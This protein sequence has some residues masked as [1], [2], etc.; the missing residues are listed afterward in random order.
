ML[1]V[2]KNACDLEK[3]SL[4]KGRVHIKNKK[5]YGNS[6]EFVY[7]E[8]LLTEGITASGY[9]SDLKEMNEFHPCR[10]YGLK[11]HLCLSF[12]GYAR[13]EAEILNAVLTGDR[14]GLVYSLQDNFSSLGITH[15]IAI[16]GLNMGIVFLLGYSFVFMIMRL[17]IPL[18]LRLDTPFAA[19][20]AGL[21]CV[22]L[23]TLFVGYSAPAVRSAIMVVCFVTSFILIRKPS[24]I[25]S[26]ALSGIII[27]LWMPG[28]LFSA[29][30]LLSFAA[31]LGL[32]GMYSLMESYPKWVVYAAVPIVSMAFTAPIVI[33]FFG[34]MSPIS[35]LANLVFVP[36]FS[37][38]I[39]PLG[40]AGI[41]AMA[42]SEYLSGHLLS[43][44]FDCISII[45]KTS[46]LVGSLEPIRCPGKAWIAV[47][48]CGLVTAFFSRPS[49][50]KNFILFPCAILVFAIPVFLQ[51]SRIYDPLC[52]DFISVGQGDSILVS[53]GSKA[54]LID[55]G[56][57]P[58]GSDTG[59]FIVG[60]HLLRRWIT[61]LDLVVITHSHPD[62]IGGMAFILKR[63][64]VKEI[65]SNVKTDWNTDFQSVIGIAQKKSIPLKNVCLDDTCHM[66]GL[67][68]EVLNPPKRIMERTE[69]LDLNLHSVVLRIGDESMKGLF[70]ADAGGLGEIRLSRL[71]RDISADVLKAAHHGSK[72]SCFSMFLDRVHPHFV[73]I[74]VGKD[75]I[76]RLPHRSVLDRLKERAIAVHRTDC[77][78]EVK[79]YKENNILQVKSAKAY[80]DNRLESASACTK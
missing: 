75:N 54:I 73:V 46:D 63:F 64:P 9:I 33:Y 80:T 24:L 66:R 43:I 60:P 72:N 31:V 4:L 6:G 45:L 69:D 35:I 27:L 67:K 28:S 58:Y 23:Y 78:G 14:S 39:M 34:F 7:Q 19:K 16:S 10:S 41:A 11:K 2:Y 53:K 1:S 79:F 51:I 42:V 30:F 74:T 36:W 55:A 71:E 65:W 25:E 38:I 15:L 8:Y 57:S 32:I 20:S 61:S 18:S 13:P 17:V 48:Y 37:F 44:A 49:L 40:I 68:V 52:F 22:I 21:V 29:S 59:R 76:Y 47:C 12:S 26:L 50:L 62:H 56:G 77:D 5:G 3:G 70:M